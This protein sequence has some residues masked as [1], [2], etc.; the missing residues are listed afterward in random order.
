MSEEQNYRQRIYE[1]YASVF[2]EIGPAFSSIAAQQ[3]SRSYDFYFKGWLP[4]NINAE[5]CDLACGSGR[6]LYYFKE[7]G[8]T[9]LSG[10]DLSL[11]QVTLARQVCPQIVH[12]NIVC[13]LNESRG[14][15][16]LIT[17][18]DII[19]HLRKEEVLPFLD[20]CYS[21]LK[22]GGRLIL[23]SPN[24]ESPW[25]SSL[26]YADF[27]HEV[28]FAPQ[29]L[30]K[31]L[32]LCGFRNVEPRQQ[33]PPRGYSTAATVRHT[34]W[35]LMIVNCLKFYNFVETGTVGSGIFTRVFLI[36][37]TKP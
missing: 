17:G 11:E 6:L 24:A 15:L 2:Q 19:E 26:R 1:K 7:K 20:L 30:T 35:R 34:I 18:M 23:Q 33:G 8:Y 5:V 21:A 36:S 29:V 22:P 25:G 4:K 13:F 3:W 14:A 31:L 27:T 10:V 12:G 9:N 28:S 32:H 16:D 37:A